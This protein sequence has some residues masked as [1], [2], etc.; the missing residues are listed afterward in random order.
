MERPRIAAEFGSI[1][2][3]ESEWQALAGA[4]AP[5][6]RFLCASWYR[7]WERHFLPHQSWRGPL[8]YLTARDSDG[9]LR[10]VVPLATQMQHGLSVGSL[11]GFYWPFRAPLFAQAEDGEAH[12]AM[13][14]A[15]TES[16]SFVAL[17]CGPVAQTDVD[18][19]RF[20]GALAKM[21]WHVHR[22]ALGTT[23]AVSLPH[24]WDEFEQRLGKSLR[25]NMNYYERRMA[26]E[27]AFEIRRCRGVRNP[28][29][30]ATLD[31]LAT[32]ERGSWQFRE[33]GT[34]RFHGD[35]NTAFWTDLLVE[36]GFGDS[37][38]AWVMHFDS[39][40]VSFGFSIDCG[41]TRHV[42]A[43]SYV[44]R[45]HRY[46]TGTV[47]YKHLFR[48][49]IESAVIQRINIGMG[50]SGY[51][52]R[53][54]AMPAFGLEDWIAFRPGLRGHALDVA[55]RVRRAL[56]NRHASPRGESD[57]PANGGEGMPNP[58]QLRRFGVLADR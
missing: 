6:N 12:H 16:R 58:G 19:A 34:M 42:L 15:L 14:D 4:A 27:G 38:A 21:G 10:A 40:P 2:P 54:A 8:R 33:G 18:V 55:W 26:R 13:A 7:A 39:E 52:S 9:A 50:D 25:S 35:R 46:S 24:G 31:D 48:D 5:E 44:E 43:N 56:G 49:T 20:G 53:W 41:E 22:C 11:G 36:G 30:R 32:I 51:K 17:R 1:A 57:D 29:W 23:H 37:A 28:A 3:T 47:L 45:M